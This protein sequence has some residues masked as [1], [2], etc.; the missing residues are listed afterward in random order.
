MIFYKILEKYY[1]EEQ[2]KLCKKN[3]RLERNK[4]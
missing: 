2:K 1:Y 3:N 4:E